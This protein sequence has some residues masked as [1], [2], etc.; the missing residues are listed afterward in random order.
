MR[1]KQFERLLWSLQALM[2]AVAT[3]DII[4]I[5]N[6]ADHMEFEIKG[7]IEANDRAWEQLKRFGADAQAVPMLTLPQDAGPAIEWQQLTQFA[8][9]AAPLA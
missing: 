1:P 5:Q 2:R 4:A 3:G 6:H 7:A 9:L 8:R